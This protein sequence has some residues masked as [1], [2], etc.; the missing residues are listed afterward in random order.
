VDVGTLAQRLT[1]AVG[2]DSQR[3]CVA[4]SPSWTG[5]NLPWTDA[6]IAVS[7]AGIAFWCIESGKFRNAR[8]TLFL[9]AYSCTARNWTSCHCLQYGH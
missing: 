4:K 5:Q 2:I 1:V 7:D 8:R 9:T 3:F 6:H